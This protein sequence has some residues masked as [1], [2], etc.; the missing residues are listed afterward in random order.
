[1]LQ[2]I[3]Q[4][5]PPIVFVALLL[6]EALAPAQRRPFS[7]RWRL[8]GFVAFMLT[9]AVF[10]LA[11][12]PWI[13]TARAHQVLHLD[14]LPTVVGA[15]LA[16]FVVNLIGYFWHRARHAVPALWRLHQLHHSAERL[17]V[18]GGP[19]FHPLEVAIM[20]SLVAG[21]SVWLL[22]ISQDAAALAGMIGFFTATFEHANVKTPRWL[23]YLIQ[24]PESHSVHH[25]RGLHAFNYADIALIDMLFGTYRNPTAREEAFGFY[26]GSSKKILPM[27]AL[28]DVSQEPAE[29]E[30]QRARG[31]R[32]LAA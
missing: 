23:G 19:L 30:A 10:R 3:A 5:F 20:G 21:V 17:D 2:T 13:E 9:G 18:S 29:E 28:I 22:G 14:G 32:R 16:I 1:M 25:A 11:P 24:R 12:L 6:L 31:R 7:L 4:V 15:L 8:Q 26:E 27:L